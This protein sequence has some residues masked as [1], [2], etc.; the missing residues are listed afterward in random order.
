MGERNYPIPRPPDDRDARFT[1]G[2]QL[3]V[4]KVLE[5]HGYPK[6]TGRDLVDL[7]LALFRFVYEPASEPVS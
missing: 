4:A 7:G 3:D 1:L 2:L 6:P 5:E